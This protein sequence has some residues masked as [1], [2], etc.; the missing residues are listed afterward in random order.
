M[1]AE[2]RAE[3]VAEFRTRDGRA[4]GTVMLYIQG[5][6]AAGKRP[7]HQAG[8]RPCSRSRC[9]LIKQSLNGRRVS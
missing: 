5:K 1:G 8:Q 4:V 7:R 9:H 2:Q 6:E 3:E